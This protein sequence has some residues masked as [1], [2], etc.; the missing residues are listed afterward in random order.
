M[1]AYE[2][3]DEREKEEEVLFRPI[4]AYD[5]FPLIDHLTYF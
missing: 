5:S 4:L 1:I 2:E 3:K